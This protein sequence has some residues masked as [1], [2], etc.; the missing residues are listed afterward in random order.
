[1]RNALFGENRAPPRPG[2]STASV[3][4]YRTVTFSSNT[5]P[6]DENAAAL[7]FGGPMNEEDM[8]GDGVGSGFEPGGAEA[9][10]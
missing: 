1:V 4:K 8:A 5:P 6:V 2:K 10:E 7:N 3:H 9:A